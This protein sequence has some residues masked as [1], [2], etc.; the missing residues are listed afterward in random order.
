MSR[1]GQVYVDRVAA[2]HALG[3][4]VRMIIDSTKQVI[5]PP[6]L[7]RA[8]IFPASSPSRSTLHEAW[9]FSASFTAAIFV[10]LGILAVGII[11]ARTRREA[12]VQL[13]L[14]SANNIELQETIKQKSRE[15]AELRARLVEATQE[16]RRQIERDLHDG[17]QQKLLAAKIALDQLRDKVGDESDVLVDIDRARDQLDTALTELREVA[18]GVYPAALSNFGLASAIESVVDGL[19][20]P[21]QMDIPTERLPSTIEAAAYFSICEALVNATKHSDCTLIQVNARREGKDILVSVQDNGR[22]GANESGHGL[23]S[24]RD[25]IHALGGDLTVDSRPG[26]GTRLVMRF[27]CE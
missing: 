24:M 23:S 22:G 7:L 17:T 6:L 13:N 19:G 20:I 12:K 5:E 1:V 9:N 14:L 10:V 18:R 2:N 11:L 26:F 25:R 8:K 4:R 27:P 3:E 21:A 16:E 15:E